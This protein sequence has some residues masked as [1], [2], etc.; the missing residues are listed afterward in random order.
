MADATASSGS[1]EEGVVVRVSRWARTPVLQGPVARRRPLGRA[2]P[3]RGDVNLDQAHD[4]LRRQEVPGQ[5]LDAGHI[6]AAGTQSSDGGDDVSL[7]E[8]R[9]VGAQAFLGV[10]E[11]GE[12]LV[13]VQARVGAVAPAHQTEHGLG[14]V[15]TDGGGLFGPATPEQFRGEALVLS[16]AGVEGGGLVGP[17]AGRRA[18]VSLPRR[19]QVGLDL[20]AALGEH[21]QLLGAEA[22]H[23]PT[24]VAVGAP[25]HLQ[26]LGEGAPQLLLVDRPRRLGP[27]MQRTG[28][29][30]A[31]A[32]VGPLDDV[33]DEAV[34]VQLRIAGPAGAMHEGGHRP[35]LCRDP[36]A[37]AGDLLAGEGGLGLQVVKSDGDGLDVGQ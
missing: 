24:A 6:E 14:L 18:R 37:D 32:A 27:V 28:I 31:V 17:H 23:L 13:V 10:D 19:L 26:A 7:V 1:G 5:F 15:E 22:D 12:D 16:V 25:G 30:A 4:V 8:P 20:D 35:A 3:G 11:V 2:A 29:D 21:A 34:G 33:G 36:G 9:V